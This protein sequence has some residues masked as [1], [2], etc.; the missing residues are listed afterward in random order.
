MSTKIKTQTAREM[1]YILNEDLVF[2]VVQAFKRY[3][4]V[5][6]IKEETGKVNNKLIEFL[7]FYDLNILIIN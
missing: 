4:I 2:E 6:L 5:N 1:K 3:L 7:D